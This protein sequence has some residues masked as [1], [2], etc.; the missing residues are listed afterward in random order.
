MIIGFWMVLGSF[1]FNYIISHNNLKYSKKYK[2]WND[3]RIE[4]TTNVIEGV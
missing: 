3:K 1:V 4:L 2:I